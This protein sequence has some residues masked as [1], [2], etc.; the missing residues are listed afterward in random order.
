MVEEVKAVAM[1]VAEPVVGREEA[2]V[3]V[4]TDWMASLAAWEAKVEV[5]REE[6]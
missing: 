5:V 1:V 3:A 6:D 2:M 4:V